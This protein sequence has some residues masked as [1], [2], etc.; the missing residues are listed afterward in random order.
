MAGNKVNL[1]CSF[2]AAFGNTEGAAQGV[3]VK[4]AMYD[5]SLRL[6][7]FERRWVRA[8]HECVE[9]YSGMH[10]VGSDMQRAADEPGFSAALPPRHPVRTMHSE[11]PDLTER[12]YALAME[13]FS[14]TALR[15]GDL[16]DSC[17]ID[18]SYVSG[19]QR[20][21]VLP[22]YVAMHLCGSLKACHDLSALRASKHG[23]TA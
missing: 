12:D 6:A 1:V 2:V 21:E 22:G 11:K 7:Y 23:S 4:Y 18:C 3:C 20:T 15:V 9:Y 14:V 8:L 19:I 17:R 5:R 16:G 10:Y 13:S